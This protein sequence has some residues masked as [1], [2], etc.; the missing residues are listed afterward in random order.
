MKK[1]RKYMK[2]KIK[3]KDLLKIVFDSLKFLISKYSLYYYMS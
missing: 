1:Q 3:K 2:K